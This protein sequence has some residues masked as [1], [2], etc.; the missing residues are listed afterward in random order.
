MSALDWLAL[1]E[2]RRE[3]SRLIDG[4]GLADFFQLWVVHIPSSA[5]EDAF[6][7]SFGAT[8]R[9]ASPRWL[10]ADVSGFL[11]DRPFASE[12]STELRRAGGWLLR[13][14][15]ASPTE[16]ARA[17]AVLNQKRDVLR[18][19]LKGPFVLALH[20]LDWRNAREE[21]TDL[22]SVHIDVIRFSERPLSD[23]PGF[24][25]REPLSLTQ[26][27]RLAEAPEASRTS[28]EERRG[29]YPEPLHP[30]LEDLEELVRAALK[31]GLVGP[32]TRR[33][34]FYGLPVWYIARLPR[35]SRPI[36]Q[37][38]SDL[39]EL[40]RTPRLDG[41]AEPP[42]AVWLAN[43]ARLT[44]PRPP[45][46]VFERWRR[47]LMGEGEPIRSAESGAYELPPSLTTALGRLPAEPGPAVL[48]LKR[49]YARTG[50]PGAKAC[51]AIDRAVASAA[52]G[53]S[54]SE[55][56]SALQIA[57][58]AAEGLGDLPLLGHHHARAAWIQGHLG[59]RRSGLAEVADGRRIRALL[60][61]AGTGR[62]GSEL[63]TVEHW[64]KTAEHE[65]PPE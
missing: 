24:P 30:R 28:S 22:W 47:A 7:A 49:A 51:F 2:N 27:S 58:S 14:G 42:L 61:R 46:M 39:M 11:R 35:A 34:L 57:R 6:A 26:L 32:E 16:V 18:G 17:A 64:L 37:L 21:A 43:A 44:S 65:A 48:H 36:D 20:P 52:A 8:L 59:D 60:G 1:G 25:L 19:M 3:W 53:L 9:A 63:D 29:L 10:Q 23:P 41:L 62:L 4:V 56:R 55:M 31:A 40:E 45:S 38:R 12:A 33:M 15:D 13:A 5:L 50:S 54:P